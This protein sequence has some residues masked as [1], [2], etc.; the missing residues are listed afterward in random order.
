[1]YRQKIIQAMFINLCWICQKSV[2]ERIV[3]GHLAPTVVGV[4]PVGYTTP[5]RAGCPHQKGCA[6]HAQDPS[7]RNDICRPSPRH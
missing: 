7:V 6:G 2:G 5:T 4:N 3:H 1:M